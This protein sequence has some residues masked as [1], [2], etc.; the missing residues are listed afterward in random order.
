[1]ALKTG[2]LGNYIEVAEGGLGLSLTADRLIV[3]MVV[4]IWILRRAAA[5]PSSDNVS[6]GE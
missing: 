4:S 6:S 3:V 1:V 2:S 5:H